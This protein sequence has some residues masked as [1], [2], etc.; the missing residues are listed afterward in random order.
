M[1]RHKPVLLDKVIEVLHPQAGESF[2]DVTG[3][4]G[5]HSAALLEVVGKSGFGYIFDQ[6]SA[7]IAALEQRFSSAENV[8]IVQANFADTVF[9]ET[10]P[11]VDMILADLGVSSPQLD[12][13]ERGFSFRA[14]GPLD[15]RM[16]TKQSLSAA[17]IVNTYREDEIAKIL[18]E[19]GEERASRRIAKA[20]VMARKVKPITTTAQLA[21][22]ISQQIK[23]SGRIHPAT[24]TFQAL[25]IAVNGEL[26]ALERFLEIV[27]SKLVSGGRIAIISFHSLEDRLVKNCFRSLS[28]ADRDNYGQIVS[29]PRF[30]RITKKPILGL[31]FDSNNPR[32]R[33]AK[34]RCLERI[35]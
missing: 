8:A 12:E 19:Y 30:K 17:E 9:E 4:W 29:E 26:T 33:S 5:G 28:T 32:A 14:E 18:Y 15:M 35:T 3:G 22:I 13:P 2:A 7:A 10:V 20:I 11:N 34:L 1:E 27:P 31:E 21:D 6:D 24:K 16:D 23:T 25:R